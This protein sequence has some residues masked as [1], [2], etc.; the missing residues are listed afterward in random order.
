MK[1]IA[2]LLVASTLLAGVGWSL[3]AQDTAAPVR[4]KV[5]LLHNE[6]TFEGEI[7]RVG[8]VYHVRRGGGETA[9]PAGQVLRLCADWDD[10]IAF[11]R[12]RANLGDPDERLRLA[13]WCHLNRQTERGREEA[14]IA[15]D[16]RPKHAETQQLVKLLELTA[17]TRNGKAASGPEPA[18]VP[19]IDLSFESVTAFTLRVQPILM[20][21][22]INC[23]SGTYGGKFRLY[24]LHEGGERVATQRNLAAVLAQVHLT[25]PAASPL[26][27]MAVSAHGNAK[28]SPIPGRQS[29]TF[30]TLYGWLEQTIADNPHLLEVPVAAALPPAAPALLPASITKAPPLVPTALPPLPGVQAAQFAP[31]PDGTPM[32]RPVLPAPTKTTPAPPVAVPVGEY[33]PDEFNRAMHPGRK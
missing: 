22:C 13:K 6:R 32:P 12:S 23:H 14:M 8:N 1:R 15:L 25:K 24:R 19:H 2:I 18:P 10:A 27:V 7:E 16:M 21:T 4:G 5:L 26:L 31:G 28:T 9:V 20:N 30:L 17:A 11:M 33:D 29:P 3:C